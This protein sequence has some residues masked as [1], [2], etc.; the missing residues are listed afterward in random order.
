MQPGES[1]AQPADHADACLIVSEILQS[2]IIDSESMTAGLRDG[3]TVKIELDSGCPQLAYH[4]SYSYGATNGRLCPGRDYVIARSG[5][6][7]RI[8]SIHP[9]VAD[10]N[11]QSQN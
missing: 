9:I 8:L 6:F 3:R 2:E 1:R 10:D 11:P 4:G 5:E 7:C